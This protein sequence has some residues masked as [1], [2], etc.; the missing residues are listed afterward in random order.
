M[1]LLEDTPEEKPAFLGVT[2][3]VK[4]FIWQDRLRGATHQ[5]TA[6]SQRH[7]LPEI[8]GRVLAGRDVDLDDVSVF[9][10][11]TL[12]ELMPDPNTLR[13]MEQG[14][15]RVADAVQNK[16]KIA[17]FGDYDVDGASSSAL[18]HRLIAAHGMESRIYIPDRIFEGYGPNETAIDTLINEG[19]RLIITVD[20]GSTSHDVLAMAKKRGVDVVIVDHHQT[21][22]VLP[23]VHSVINPNRQDDLSGLGN[24][25]AA[26]VVFMLLVAVVRELRSRG[27]YKDTKAP[28]L[29]QLLDIVALATVC[30]V[31]PLHG[32]NRALV[33]KGLQVMRHRQNVGLRMLIDTAGLKTAP[34]PYHLG[35][36]I[37]PRINAGGR[38]GDAG[39]GA[40]LLSMDDEIEADRISQLLDKLNK[41]RKEMENATLEEALAQ[42]D[43]AVDQDPNIPILITGAENWHKGLV[44]L[45]SSRLTDKFRRPSLVISWQENGEG[46]GSARS[47]GGVD[48]GSVVREAVAQELLVK[49]GGHAMAAGLT[50]KREK[51]EDLKLFLER[52]LLHGVTQARDKAA[53]MVDGALTPNS[54]SIDLMDLLD[55]A[56][57]YGQGNPSPRFVFPSHR[58]NYAKV[59]GENHIK[60]TLIASDGSKI[61]AIAF[62]AVGTPLGDLMLDRSQKTMHIA[63]QLTRND[64]GGREKVELTIDDIALPSMP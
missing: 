4:G 35:F 37:G 58:I 41:E 22:E 30:D 53:L 5:A 32:L 57:P 10:D 54:V 20:C 17:I 39:L 27:L 28:D 23:D 61:N 7:D 51:F 6:I 31:V 60:C 8:L 9:L 50:V 56:G 62:R 40:R 34:T 16:E 19:A 24:L 3:S 64:W 42:A 63:G 21:D 47:I 36:V 11:P 46:T 44:G 45:V 55:K 43:Y 15:K 26:G 52:K 18:L 49:G 1:A 13:D 12:K 2:E 48:L 29:L 14:A 33:T 38:I 25:A 59:I